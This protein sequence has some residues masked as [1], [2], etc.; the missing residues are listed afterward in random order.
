MIL[1]INS[2]QRM[3]GSDFSP[4]LGA[5]A[6]GV[7]GEERRMS[8]TGVRHTTDRPTKRMRY[9]ARALALIWAGWW[10]FCSVAS[11]ALNFSLIWLLG[12]VCLSLFLLA[13]A[14]FPRRWEAIG[15]VVLVLEGLALFTAQMFV[16]FGGWPH[17][18][19]V[20]AAGLPPLVAG[21][22]FLAS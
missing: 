17:I 20:L 4:H 2:V 8:M 9:I 3:R 12:S 21:I 14:T 19:A 22:L 7:V 16:G 1:A 18:L 6:Q 5:K 13:S 11:L 15:G 10:A